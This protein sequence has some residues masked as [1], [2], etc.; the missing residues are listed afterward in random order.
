MHSFLQCFRLSKRNSN[1]H[2]HINYMLM[3]KLAEQSLRTMH[4]QQRLLW[5]WPEPCSGNICQLRILGT[6]LYGKSKDR[7]KY[8][9]PVKYDG[10]ES[11]QQTPMREMCKFDGRL[12][13][14]GPEAYPNR[15]NEEREWKLEDKI[16]YNLYCIIIRIVKAST[17]QR[18]TQFIS[19]EYECFPILQ[20]SRIWYIRFLV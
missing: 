13:A 1:P 6:L 20:M 3:R 8:Y 5:I 2:W 9:E 19:R 18:K 17:D 14:L 4:L 11:R 10:R 7:V 15:M 12:V 16:I